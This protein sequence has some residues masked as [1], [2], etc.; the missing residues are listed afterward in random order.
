MRK[1]F[2]HISFLHVYHHTAMV[3]ATYIAVRFLPAGHGTMVAVLNCLVH[4]IMYGYYLFSVL[5]E[6][7]KK[8]IWW[9][10]HITQVQM[11]QFLLL[12]IHFAWALFN[13]DCKYPK[14]ISFTM[15]VQNLFMLFMFGDF[16]RNAYLK[17]KPE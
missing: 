4:A 8:S 1:R 17:K 16:Y 14:L 7:V 2:S 13:E 9:K 12:G 15:A 10:K 11:C 5:N 3:V 6:N